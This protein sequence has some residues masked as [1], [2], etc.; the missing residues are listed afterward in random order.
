MKKM[1]WMAVV[2]L[3]AIIGLAVTGQGLAGKKADEKNKAEGA[4]ISPRFTIVDTNCVIDNKNGLMWARNAS[5][6]G[7]NQ[8]TW[9]DAIAFC[10]NLN[11]GGHSDWRL[12]NI[13]EFWTLIDTKYKRLV[14][15]N[16]AGT[17]Q[18]K[19]NDPFTGVQTIAGGRRYYWATTTT[20]GKPAGPWLISMFCGTVARGQGSET[21]TGFVWPVREVKK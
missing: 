17:G 3:A 10:K 12:P 8:P 5:L 16:T 21:N 2:S 15:P 1:R 18:M 9:A 13:R 7:T 6:N 19:N 4:S 11:Y 14:I 20:A